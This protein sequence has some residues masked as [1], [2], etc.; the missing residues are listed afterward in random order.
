MSE[1]VDEV[2]KDVTTNSKELNHQPFT[3]TADQL[4]HDRCG[5]S[6][7]YLDTTSNMQQYAESMSLPLNT[8]TDFSKYQCLTPVNEANYKIEVSHMR[9]KVSRYDLEQI[10]DQ[11]TFEDRQ[12]TIEMEMED[13][14]RS[15]DRGIRPGAVY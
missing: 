5:E 6:E 13:F 12:N 8:C 10:E 11:I 3:A 1:L 2:I 4:S 9:G 14:N 15:P 7:Y